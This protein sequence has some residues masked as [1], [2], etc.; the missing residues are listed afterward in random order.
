MLSPRQWLPNSNIDTVVAAHEL[1]GE[2]VYLVLKRQARF[3]RVSI[4]AIDKAIA[5]SRAR[6]RIR[7]VDEMPTDDLP[8]LYAAADCVVS[9]CTTDGTPVSLLEAMAVGRPVVALQNPSV[10]EWVS[11]PGGRVVPRLVTRDI[12]DS[13][14][15]VLSPRARTEAAKHNVELVARRADRAAEMVRM[16]DLYAALLSLV[17]R[18]RRFDG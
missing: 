18:R 6:E 10:M 12:A 3:E 2:D 15:S 11:E 5:E 4:D 14:E 1:L 9:L 13:I 17:P 8:Q 7:V 16:A